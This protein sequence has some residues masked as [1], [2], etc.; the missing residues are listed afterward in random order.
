MKKLLSITIS[1]LLT[2]HLCYAQVIDHAQ[3]EVRYHYEMVGNRAQPDR[4]TTDEVILLIGN[5]YTAYYSWMN[6]VRDS[7]IKENP[8][9]YQRQAR[10]GSGRT[11]RGNEDPAT[12]TSIRVEPARTELPRNQH[13][14]GHYFI[15]RSSGEVTFLDQFMTGGMSSLS[16]A[17][18][19]Y[20]EPLEKPDWII[21]TETAEVAGYS[22]QKATTRYGGRDWTVWFTPEI[23]V[24]EGPWKL[25]GLPGLILK[26]ETADGEFAL[27]ATSVSRSTNR[28]IAKN[29]EHVYRNVSKRDFQR[30]Q[31]EATES[32]LSSPGVTIVGSGSLPRREVNF[33]EILE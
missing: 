21:E 16:M 5:R 4:K 20:T 18:F 11:I 13:N 14:T 29:Q 19:S 3:L 23:P 1:L 2:S 25:R 22:T 24:S 6:F 31:R 30:L 32:I 26:A 7:L 10:D 8:A 15:N 33:I 17:Y 9:Q 28:A 12:I 27:T